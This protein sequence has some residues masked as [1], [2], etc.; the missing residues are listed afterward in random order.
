MT[1]KKMMYD[2]LG[3]TVVK[4]LEKRHFAAQYC[5][6][7]EEA[8]AAALALIEEGKVVGWGGSQTVD[9]L[10]IKDALREKGQPMLDRDNAAAGDKMA[11]MKQG[12]TAD[13]FLMSSNAITRDGKLVNVD[14]CG[15]RVAALIFG[16]EKVIVVAGMNKV[17]AA[18]EDAVSRVRNWAAPMNAQRFQKGTPCCVTGAC[19]DCLSQDSIC[20]NTVITRLCKPAGRI[21][22]ILVGE[23]LG[24]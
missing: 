24:M 18:E 11:I 16:P 13:V 6:T 19:A 20:A 7:A 4:A 10:K 2:T 8:K 12:L 14:G 23:D 1:P 17:V 9:A 21:H 5:S 3:P 15:N 22:V